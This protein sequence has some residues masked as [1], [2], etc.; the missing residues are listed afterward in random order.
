MADVYQHRRDRL[1][2][3]YLRHSVLPVCSSGHDDE[4][5]LRR[6]HQRFDRSFRAGLVVRWGE[7]VS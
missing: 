4:Y 6:Y 5:E 7:E 1:D 3:I 2:I